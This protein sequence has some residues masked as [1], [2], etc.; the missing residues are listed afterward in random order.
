MDGSSVK[1]RKVVMFIAYFLLIVALI[2]IGIIGREYHSET[3]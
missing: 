2:Y 1:W 3:P